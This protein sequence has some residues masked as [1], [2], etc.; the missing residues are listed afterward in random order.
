MR[1]GFRGSLS[2]VGV[3]VLAAAA[4]VSS[5]AG[6]GFWLQGQPRDPAEEALRA[7]VEGSGPRTAELKAVSADHPGT[8]A[9]GLARLEA[10][11]RL[12]DERRS[13]EAI[14]FLAHPDIRQTHLADYALFALGEAYANTGDAPRAA[15]AHLSVVEQYPASP[16]RCPALLDAADAEA[17]SGRSDK[18]IALLE[19]ALKDCPDSVPGTLAAVGGMHQSRKE[20]K[21]A[22]DA[23]AR[24]DRE[25]PASPA[26][27]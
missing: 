6:P 25:F 1:V 16:L 5:A 13:A 18:G 20:L 15:A 9:S 23:F 21:E 12:L 17:S 14:P 27:S 3:S 7:A 19:Q 4:T 10:G 24:L 26:W 11:L 8:L 2:L 22:A